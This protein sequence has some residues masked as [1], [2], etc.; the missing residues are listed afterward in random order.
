MGRRKEVREADVVRLAPEDIGDVIWFSGP[1]ALENLGLSAGLIRELED[2]ER[3]FHAHLRY[4]QYVIDIESMPYF[5]DEGIRLARCLANEIGPL[6]VVE[7][8]PDERYPSPRR[9]RAG[10]RATNSTA[11]RVFVQ[12]AA[13]DEEFRNGH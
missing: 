13:D 3:F 1:I 4:N 8:D 10:K 5:R 7:F 9:F 2:W 11:E 12:L 6:F